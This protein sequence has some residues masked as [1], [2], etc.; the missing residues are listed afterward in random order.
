[1]IIL[2]RGAYT[3]ELGNKYNVTFKELRLIPYVQYTLLNHTPIDRRCIN[4]DEDYILTIW[5]SEGK[6][7]ISDDDRLSC[8]KEF[9][10]WMNAILW[11]SYVSH[12]G[13]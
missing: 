13:E 12:L 8:T 1:M 10:D 2:A 5:E 6:I 9:W 3:E 7:S 11:E 4:D